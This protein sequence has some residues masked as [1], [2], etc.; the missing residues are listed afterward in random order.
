MLLGT[1]ARTYSAYKVWTVAFLCDSVYDR[2][3]RDETMKK[4][5]ILLLAVMIMMVVGACSGGSDGSDVSDD[6]VNSASGALKEGDEAPDFTAELAAGGTYT[7]SDHKDDVVLLNFWATWC[8]YCVDEMPEIQ[9]IADEN[10]DGVS[11][12]L[13][14]CMETRQEVDDFLKE[15]G[16]TF[17][18]AYDEDGSIE[19]KYPTDGIP[20]TLIIK[21]GVIKKIYVGAPSDPYNEYKSAIEECLK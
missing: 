6:D 3:R 14:D 16:F 10:L 21:D 13:V 19:E 1:A 18:A 5:L 9:K 4:I 8:G 17:D 12:I 20:Y 15:N 2:S 7:L 11:I